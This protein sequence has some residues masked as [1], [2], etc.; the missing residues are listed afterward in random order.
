MNPRQKVHTL[1][2]IGQLIICLSLLILSI[3]GCTKNRKRA[4]I[5]WFCSKILTLE[6]IVEKNAYDT[7][8]LI[9]ISEHGNLTY[10]VNYLELLEDSNKNSKN[11]N[12]KECGIL[13]SF[14]NIMLVPNS[15]DCPI[16]D[17]KINSNEM[18]DRSVILNDYTL[19][20]NNQKSKDK[21]IVSKIIISDEKPK[22]ISKENFIFDKDTYAD[23]KPISSETGGGGVGGWGG[24]RRRRRRRRR[25]G[26]RR[27]RRGNRW[28]RWWF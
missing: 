5:V 24:G 23:T 1:L 4:E 19:Y 20:Y 3:I 21:S 15:Q 10:N 13:D 17:I 22:Y 2:L 8:S 12:F 9:E 11:E 25:G 6:R 7:Y 14:G 16:N 28:R 27:R 26:R 18:N